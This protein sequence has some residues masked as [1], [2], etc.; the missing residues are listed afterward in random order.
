MK[1]KYKITLLM[2]VL[3]FA[4]FIAGCS[5]GQEDQAS[6]E[7]EKP[8]LT[9]AYLPITHSLPLAVAYEQTGGEFENF[10]LE[11][12]RFSSWPELTEALN[13]GHV[14]GAITMFEI[15]MAGAERGIPAETQLLTHRNGDVF[16]VEENIQSVEEVKGK[17]IATPHRLSGHTI[18]LYLTLQQNDIDLEE[19]EIIEMPPPE[20]PAALSRG[21]ISG[22]V[23][24]EPFGAQ[25]VAA[26][27]GKVLL[28]AQDVWPD[29]ICCGLV[30]NP[31]ISEKYPEANEEL[32]KALV[33]AGH[34]IENNQEE[35]ITIAGEVME[36][37]E[38]LWELSLEWISYDNLEPTQKEFEKLQEL[39]IELPW[40]G[41]SHSLLSEEIDLDKFLNLKCAEKA[42]R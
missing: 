35:A 6:R 11:I 36:I 7:N 26:E 18:Y 22:Y 5:D 27:S 1:N 33:D 40:E 8:V 37:E 39:L 4:V 3:I 21:Q 2:A 30:M 19:I 38:E 16:V 17:T 32:V 10:E 28:R 20:M 24:A 25:S 31:S 29:W 34:F 41:E 42:T 13:A 9:I 14:D 12:V 15:A 23:V